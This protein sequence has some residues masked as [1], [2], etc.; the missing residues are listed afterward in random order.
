MSA[1]GER[2]RR[3]SEPSDDVEPPFEEAVPCAEVRRRHLNERETVK[4]GDAGPP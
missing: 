1:T 2:M 3:S 4:V